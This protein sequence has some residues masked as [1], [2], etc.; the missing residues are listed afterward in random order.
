M[1][2]VKLRNKNEELEN[3]IRLKDLYINKLIT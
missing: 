1:E 2:I 3:I